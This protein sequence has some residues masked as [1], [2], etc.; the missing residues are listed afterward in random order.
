MARQNKNTQKALNECVVRIAV[1]D[2]T[3]TTSIGNNNA[4]I[5]RG[6]TGI[7]VL[8]SGRAQPVR[9]SG[10]KRA[11]P[12]GSWVKQNAVPWCFEYYSVI[13]PLNLTRY[14]FVTEYDHRL[15]QFWTKCT[16]TNSRRVSMSTDRLWRRNIQRSGT[17]LRYHY[18]LYIIRADVCVAKQVEIHETVSCWLNSETSAEVKEA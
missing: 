1:N 18:C 11:S 6:Y 2:V 8:S 9:K 15:V 5:W 7:I 17:F 4:K 12:F 14:K 13:P 10:V 3:G 16:F